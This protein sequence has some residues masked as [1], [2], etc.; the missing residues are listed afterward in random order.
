MIRAISAHA[1]HQPL[2]DAGLVPPNCRLMDVRIGV[3]GAVFVSYEA[4]LSP[5]QLVTFGGILAKVAQA[6]LDRDASTERTAPMTT[7]TRLPDPPDP[8]PEPKPIGDPPKP[9]DD[10][11]PSEQSDS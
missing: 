4:F 10:G 11:T 9:D 2:Q 3:D 8:E 7:P 5:A 1:F 6:A